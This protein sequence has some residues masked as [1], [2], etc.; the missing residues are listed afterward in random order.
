MMGR[1]TAPKHVVFLDKS[2]FQKLVRL[3]VLL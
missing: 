1:G 3:L 2:K